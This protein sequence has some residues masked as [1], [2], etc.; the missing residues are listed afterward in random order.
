MATPK[1]TPRS[2]V[3]TTRSARLSTGATDRMREGTLALGTMSAAVV[4]IVLGV[5]CAP[6]LTPAVSPV[7]GATVPGATAS[8]PTVERA[9]RAGRLSADRMVRVA[10]A[11]GAVSAPISATD[12][13]QVDE[14]GGA[15]LLVRGLGGEAWRIE[16]RGGLLRLAGD[17]GDAT[18][19]RQGPFVARPVGA[20]QGPRGTSD[21]ALLQY[22]GKRYRGELWFTAT[23]SGVLVVNRLP[24]EDYLRGVVP[25]ELGVRGP[26][27]RAA[28][29]AQ[30]IAARSY[31]YIRVP[32]GDGTSLPSSGWHVVATV[33]NQ[34]YGGADVE[35]PIVNQ[36]IDATAGLVLRYG[37]LIVDAP[38]SSSCGGRTASTG[39]AWR[40]ARDQPYLQ[41]VDDTD[42]TT[43]RPYCDISP[44][45]HWTE[46]L[47]DERLR[48]T[49]RRAL[50]AAG[51]RDPAGSNVTDLRVAERTRSG[52]IASLTMRTERGDVSVRASDL[53]A[54]FQNARG[55]I[56]SST[57][58]SVERE[59][60]ARGALTGVTLR[61][62]GNGHGVGMC[63]WGAIGRSRAG[64]DARTI[65]RHYYPGTV[66]GFAD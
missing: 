7:P 9:E 8:L 31:T 19:W 25:I 21:A 65:L 13:W 39:E 45:N 18:P 56:L 14:N 36:A 20:A 59:S 64:Q 47:D 32:A 3:S 38:Y 23:D 49:V 42:Q 50:L 28:L 26:A 60:R 51:A 40:G 30:A 44:R 33:S 35:H 11:G 37:G 55:A 62:A 10:L 43:G 63:Q 58:F 24:V 4:A 46:E 66:V 34:V 22:Q 12:A 48:Q 2:T 16:Q 41:P 52:R 6:G 17:G 57:Q 1:S 53:R 29:E 15:A 5:A 61:G 54:V 27:D